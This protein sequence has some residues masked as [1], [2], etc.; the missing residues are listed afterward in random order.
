MATYDDPR[1]SRFAVLEKPRPPLALILRVEIEEQLY[2]P[3]VD[4]VCLIHI[5]EARAISTVDD[6]Q[7]YVSGACWVRATGADIH[8]RD[9]VLVHEADHA[10]AQARGLLLHQLIAP[11]PAAGARHEHEQLAVRSEEHTS[12]LQSPVNLVCRL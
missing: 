11:R 5:H 3:V 12:E 9:I 8:H 6:L 10:V 2:Q 7:P 1:P 4:A